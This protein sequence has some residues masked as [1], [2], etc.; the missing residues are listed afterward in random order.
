MSIRAKPVPEALVLRWNS[1]TLRVQCPYCLYS[2]RHGLPGSLEESVDHTQPRRRLR[3]FQNRRRSD[4]EDAN[5]GGD[6]VFVFPGTNNSTASSYGWEV[7]REDREFTTM[8]HDGTVIVPLN[9]YHDGRTLLPEHEERRQIISA[10]GDIKDDEDDADDLSTAMGDLDL[11]CGVEE[12]TMA[13]S[14]NTSGDE[15]LEKLYLDPGFRRKMYFSHCILREVRELEVLC[16]RYPDD[17]L[18]GC[19]DEEG[20]TGALLAATEENGLKTLTWLQHRGDSIRRANHYG[21]TPLMEAAL[22]GRLETVQ[23]LTQQSIDLEARD[24][25]G[26]QAADL[27]ADTKR[28]AKERA[29]RSGQVYRERSDA[30]QKRDQVKALLERLTSSERGPTDRKIAMQRRAFFS[31]APDG[32][33]E[34]YRPQVLLEPPTGPHG[35]QLQKAFA[36]LDRGPNYPYVNAM[37]G[38]THHSWPNVLDNEVWTDRAEALRALFGLTKNKSAASHVE[39]QL[40]AYLLD[41]HTLLQWPGE[42]YCRELTDTIPA[43]TLRSIITVSKPDLCDKCIVFFECFKRRFP[44]F[45]VLFHCVGDS[46]AAP[47][48][49]RK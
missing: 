36:T 8:N 42:D 26:M 28:N 45:G 41:R 39:P 35:L 23:Y 24:G 13:T 33:L 27:A 4:C 20:N 49:V 22:W 18:I 25:N 6:Y 14:R 10:I 9:D 7:N 5:I 29:Q 48:L 21:R 17:H 30:S 11:E 16:Y 2:H 47:L 31:R 37:S 34:V 3:S 1:R 12:R 43:C 32:K 38:Y 46:V 44:D 15:I 19:V 40:L